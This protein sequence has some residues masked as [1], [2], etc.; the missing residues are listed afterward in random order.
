MIY[1]G[2]FW[3]K[4]NSDGDYD[5]LPESYVYRNDYYRPA[6]NA[7]KKDEKIVGA[8]LLIDLTTPEIF[9]GTGNFYVTKDGY[10][11]ASAGGDL[12][13]WKIRTEEITDSAGNK[14]KHSVL[15]SNIPKSNG[16]ITLDAGTLN[17]ETGTVTGPGKIYSHSHDELTKT[18]N[19]FYLSYD[20]LSIGSKAK[21]TNTG[22]MYIGNGAVAKGGLED[23]NYW[24]IN[25]NNSRSYISYGGS[26][27]F[28]AASN[29]DGKTAKVYVGTDGISLGTRFSVNSQG[30]L[31][32]YSGKIG[33]WD[34]SKNKISAGKISLNANGSMSGGSGDNTWSIGKD[35]KATF[36]YLN[37][38]KGG[39]LGGWIIGS[40]YLKGG[41][42][43]L[44]SNGV[45]QGPGWSINSKGNTSGITFGSS[46][47]TNIVIKTAGAYIGNKSGHLGSGG[48]GGYSGSA[49]LSWSSSGVQLNKGAK[50]GGLNIRDDGVLYFGN[51]S[52]TTVIQKNAIST[53]N[54]LNF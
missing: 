19:G 48:Y 27:S 13:G 30:V 12:A 22:V 43:T 33:G 29:D 7:K 37:A 1:S 54:I 5:G 40:N 17:E 10:I 28:A 11:H 34:I 46:G 6:G 45:I 36:N 4:Y 8:G 47:Q 14:A 41:N 44:Y 38:S 16:R 23:G 15:R 3:E 51:G 18:G 53:K 2:N 24:T 26:T 25:G 9:F 39:K 42:M 35:G 52:G 31:T 32:A 49:P 20:G 21:L 50:I